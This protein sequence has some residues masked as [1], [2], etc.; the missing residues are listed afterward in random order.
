ME[1]VSFFFFNCIFLFVI[2][3]FQFLEL[4]EIIIVK[5]INKLFNLLIIQNNQGKKISELILLILIFWIHC[6]NE[7]I[8]QADIS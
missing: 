1:F 5:I 6:M 7:S 2:S 3:E 8:L 4:H